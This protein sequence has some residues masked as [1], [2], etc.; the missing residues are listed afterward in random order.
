MKYLLFDWMLED[1]SGTLW[2]EN[3]KRKHA[4]T[5]EHIQSHISFFFINWYTVCPNLSWIILLIDFV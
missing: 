3:V 1:V 2:I 5:R 4:E